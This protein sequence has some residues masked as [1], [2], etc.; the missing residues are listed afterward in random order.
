MKNSKLQVKVGHK[1][2]VTLLPSEYL[3]SGGEAAIYKKGSQIFKIYHD[4]SDGS[5]AD[6]EEKIALLQKI[7]GKGVVSP[8]EIL[9]KDK[10]N[11]V[12]GYTMDYI[13]G[14]VLARYFS[15]EHR[16][17]VGFSLQ[18]TVT[19]VKDMQEI[20]SLAHHH[21]AVMVD[22]NELNYIINSVK[23]VGVID[24]DSW[25]IG[26]F[27]AQVI[28]PTIR[29][30]HTNGF[31]SM[32][33]WFSW[34]VVTFQ[35][36]TGI[37]PYKGRHLAYKPN[38][39]ERRM[40]DNISVFDPAVKVSSNIRSW[41]DIP[42][43][44][45]EWYEQMFQTSNRSLPPTLYTASVKT[46]QKMKSKTVVASNGK[47]RMDKLMEVSGDIIHVYSDGS[48]LTDTHLY[49]NG[50]MG[51]P[52]PRSKDWKIFRVGTYFCLPSQQDYLTCINADRL[53]DGMDRVH[54]SS[55]IHKLM[56]TSERVNPRLFAVHNSGMTELSLN[57]IGKD[58]TC[59]SGQT[60]SFEPQACFI[61][62]GVIIYD[63]L[64][65]PFVVLPLGEKGCI[66]EKCDKLQDRTILAAKAFRSFVTC[67]VKD[68]KGQ[69]FTVQMYFDPS[70]G[71]LVNSWEQQ[72]DD[73][74]LNFA[75]TE[76]GI[77]VSVTE[78][79]CADIFSPAHNYGTRL[80]NKSITTDMKL[81]SYKGGIAFS[82]DNQLW[83]M[84]M[85]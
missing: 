57:K 5:R 56:M 16:S 67:L 2:T 43:G 51:R 84:S 35:L 8:K 45:L 48:I 26:R 1:G 15:N 54:S 6:M 17:R 46:L 75:V 23:T 38:E 76:K 11:D 66:M 3:T 28:M 59:F 60:W 68:R 29:D 40:K 41:S 21:S 42:K 4:T 50:N 47:I 19:C 52:I 72:T 79:G 24:V 36:F 37:H 7:Q 22:A 9:Y 80:Q 18:D 71:L 39:L 82:L 10:T 27:K 85:T 33:D 49:L 83:S 77:V 53:G 55:V 73:T 69:N 44:L 31:N 30:H 14:E 81:F 34:A 61:G 13:N 20:V 58:L 64:G 65:T 32:S 63:A 62:D 70:S 12:V 74:E 78:D 25:Q